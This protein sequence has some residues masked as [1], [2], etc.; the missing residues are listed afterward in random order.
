MLLL[1][2]LMRYREVLKQ[3]GKLGFSAFEVRSLIKARVIRGNSLRPGGRTFYSTAQITRDVLQ[4]RYW[5]SKVITEPRP[6]MRYGTMR[7]WLGEYGIAECEVR[8][9][10]NGGVIHC[11]KA[12]RPD[13]RAYY[14]TAQIQR[15][16][17][18]PLLGSGAHLEEHATATTGPTRH[19]NH[20]PSS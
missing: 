8:A 9:L 1:L 16:V 11:N 20:S 7:N 2:P 18:D 5:K 17:L 19:T 13:G 14:M 12:F 10:I 3:L 15:D 4:E 6:F